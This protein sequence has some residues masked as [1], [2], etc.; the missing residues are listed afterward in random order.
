MNI[1]VS[2]FEGGTSVDETNIRSIEEWTPAAVTALACELFQ[3]WKDN[4]TTDMFEGEDK[5]IRDTLQEV[6]P[7]RMFEGVVDDNDGG[8]FYVVRH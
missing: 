1:I 5:Y 2:I 6:I 4:A 3:D 8:T 7:G